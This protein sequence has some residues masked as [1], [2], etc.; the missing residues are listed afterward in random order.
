[1]KNNFVAI[2]DFGSSK[3]TCMAASKVSDKGEF[4]IKAVGQSI[5]NGFGDNGWYEPDT[6]SEAVS[7]AISQVE[8]KMKSRIKEIFVGVP[9]VFCAQTTSEASTTFHSKKKIDVDDIEEIIKKADIFKCESDYSPLG[10]KPVYFILDGALKM[11]EPVGFIA[12]KLTE[13]I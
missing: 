12:S 5:Y 4:I 1:M 9:G 6:I 7:Q 10:G 11:V 3:I 8:N 2:L 13:L